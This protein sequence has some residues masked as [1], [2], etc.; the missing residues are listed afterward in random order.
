MPADVYGSNKEFGGVLSGSSVKLSFSGAADG[1]DVTTGA[2][3]QQ[4][5][6]QYSRQVNRILELGSD[7]QYYVVGQ[8]QGQG[9]FQAMLGPTPIMSKLISS[10]GDLCQTES[11]VVNLSTSSLGDGCTDVGTFKAVCKNVIL[12]ST[13]VSMSVQDFTVR[14][15]GQFMFM[16]MDVSDSA[17]AAE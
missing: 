14:N 3:L 16:A 4:V 7:K 9:S 15:G 5:Q 11:N 12:T 17:A 8:S 2:L 10:L 6:L 1:G 13:N